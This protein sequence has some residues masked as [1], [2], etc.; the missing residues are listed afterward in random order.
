MTDEPLPP[1]Q[2]WRVYSVAPAPLV[3]ALEEDAV[4]DGEEG[5][6]VEPT[7]AGN[8]EAAAEVQAE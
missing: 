2:G 8:G 6:V 1:M 3:I 5:S 4:V 7:D